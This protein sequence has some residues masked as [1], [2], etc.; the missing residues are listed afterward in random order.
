M[1][2]PTRARM[3]AC[4]L[5]GEARTEGELAR[6][7]GVTPQAAT[8]QLAQPEDAGLIC[9]R[10]QGRHTQGRIQLGHAGTRLLQR[11]LSRVLAGL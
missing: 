3:L 11:G 7:G 10:R 5:G 2:E 1:A 9:A 8:S 6:A 4:R